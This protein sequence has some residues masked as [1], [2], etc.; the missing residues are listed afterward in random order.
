ML[1]QRTQGCMGGFFVISMSGY[2][3][4]FELVSE[5]RPAFRG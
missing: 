3:L 2:P 1:S 4:S 5:S